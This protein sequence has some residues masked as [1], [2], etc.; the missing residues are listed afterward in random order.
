[1]AVALLAAL[2]YETS[3]AETA[4]A[5]LDL[6]AAAPPFDLMLSDVVLPDMK[7]P[8]LAE[9]VR[10]IAPDIA[11]VYMT[12]YAAGAFE[13]HGE[14]DKST[15]LINKPFTKAELARVIHDTLRFK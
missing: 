3:D 9:Q 10:R 2:G 5:A 8:A 7:G 15:R 6:I 14:E 4:E 1:Q 13:H 11:V 12:G